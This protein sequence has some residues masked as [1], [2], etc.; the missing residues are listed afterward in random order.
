LRL[1]CIS[2]VLAATVLSGVACANTKKEPAESAARY[3]TVVVGDSIGYEGPQNPG[4]TPRV[5]ESLN[6]HDPAAGSDITLLFPVKGELDV[7]GGCLGF[8]LYH[9]L[10]GDELG[11]VEP[12]LQGGSTYCNKP[13]AVRQQAEGV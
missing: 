13:Q 3:K 6:G 9:E 2:T 10:E 12:G 8:A 5:L 1:M 4:D 7:E 11:G